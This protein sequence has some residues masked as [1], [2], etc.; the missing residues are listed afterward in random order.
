MLK[1]RIFNI[2]ILN[3]VLSH[4]FKYVVNTW[5]ILNSNCASQDTDEVSSSRLKRTLTSRLHTCNRAVITAVQV[6]YKG[7]TIF[8]LFL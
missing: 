7:Y 3:L 4:M 6:L 8:I 2:T 1:A 5:H